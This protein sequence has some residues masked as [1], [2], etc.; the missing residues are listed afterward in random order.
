V[1]QTSYSR[2]QRNELLRVIARAFAAE[3]KRV[4]VPNIPGQEG[5]ALAAALEII[6][7][8]VPGKSRLFIPHYWAQ[9]LHDDRKG[10]G[11]TPGGGRKFLVWFPNPAN[12]PRLAGGYPVRFSDVVRLDD[13]WS[14]EEFEAALARGPGYIRLARKVGPRK[15]TFFFTR[16]MRPFDEGPKPDEIAFDA[17]DA[18]AKKI[19]DETSETKPIVVGL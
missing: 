6:E 11:P 9:Y 1:A 4:A 7:G 3:A 2:E 17:F 14:T 15:G 16:G 19:A 12:D 8:P 10:F 18:F 13:V 5:H